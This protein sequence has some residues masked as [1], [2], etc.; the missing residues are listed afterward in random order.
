MSLGDFRVEPV[1]QAAVANRYIVKAGSAASI[2]AGEWVVQNTGGDVEYVTVATDGAANTS[3]WVGVAATTSTDT[4]AADG[5][6]Y[7][8]DNPDDKF[9]GKPTTAANLADALLL[10]QVTLDVSS[11][12][13]TIDENDT[14]NG[15][16]IV[17]DYDT[18]RG[19]I[20]VQMARAD[21]IS[22]G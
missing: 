21:H 11:S 20:T 16:L 6:V 10:T 13:Q 7:V 3:T 2:K 4:A 1:G 22:Q 9:V 8:F 12:D 18:D 15:T 19:E 5:E 17:K 14:V